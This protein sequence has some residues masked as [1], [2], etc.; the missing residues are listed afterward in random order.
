MSDVKDESAKEHPPPQPALDDES[1]E[2]WEDESPASTLDRPGSG[3]RRTTEVHP[4][5]PPVK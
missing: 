1:R 3:R 5:K 2:R 4:R